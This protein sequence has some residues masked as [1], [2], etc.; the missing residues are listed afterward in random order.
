M[1]LVLPFR[2]ITINTFLDFF[3]KGK[4]KEFSD[5]KDWKRQ[6]ARGIFQ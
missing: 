2:N 3:E 1:Q 5:L 6:M 4:D